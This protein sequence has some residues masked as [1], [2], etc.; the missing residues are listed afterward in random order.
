M[1]SL[2]NRSPLDE[3]T[4]LLNEHPEFQKFWEV[5][6]SSGFITENMNSMGL[7]Y[8]SGGSRPTATSFLA[9]SFTEK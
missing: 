3:M 2:V 1:T 8:T 9:S 4:R 6:G 5:G 7:T